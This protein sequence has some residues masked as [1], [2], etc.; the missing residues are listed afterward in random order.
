MRACVS[1]C[2]TECVLRACVHAFVRACVRVGV[3]G[4]ADRS[5]LAK[6]PGRNHAVHMQRTTR[7]RRALQA[8][9]VFY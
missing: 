4:A 1:E 5:V 8:T 9:T 6:P 3:H 2:V 7:A